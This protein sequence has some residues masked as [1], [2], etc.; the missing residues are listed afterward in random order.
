M[1][2]GQE[3]NIA[4]PRAAMGN[5]DHSRPHIFRYKSLDFNLSPIRFN[6]DP[7]TILNPK[8]MSHLWIHLC[9]GLRALL[10]QSPNISVLFS[11]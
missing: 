8:L 11:L 1:N 2:V 9:K 5:A 4:F 6:N 7:V 10:L 3:I